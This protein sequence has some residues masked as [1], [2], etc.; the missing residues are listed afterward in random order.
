M[1]C[2]TMYKI[3][4]IRNTDEV[5][6]LVQEFSRLY[7]AKQAVKAIRKVDEARGLKGVY[8]Y[9]II[10]KGNNAEN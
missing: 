7:E 6:I 9:E 1:E 2:K 8:K 10:E 3:K 4:L 5:H